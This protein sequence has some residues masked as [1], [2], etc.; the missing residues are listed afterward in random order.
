MEPNPLAAL[1]DE[2]WARLESVSARCTLSITRD[3]P[4]R[5]TLL[6]CRRTWHV[7][8]QDTL[9][10]AHDWVGTEA[11]TLAEA[12]A[13]AVG[14]A[15]ARG[16]ATGPSTPPSPP[17]AAPGRLDGTAATWAR[18]RAFDPHCQI[19]F[20]RRSPSDPSPGVGRRMWRVSIKDDCEILQREASAEDP[21][22]ADALARLLDQAEARGWQQP[23]DRRNM[24][25]S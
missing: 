8:V 2:L 24:L 13:A 12:V 20:A 15:L 21:T 19:R 1:P 3:A 16:W 14:Q 4:T 7:H 9:G 11:P 17:T 25:T 18:L 10:M 6:H 23:R 22:L 5:A